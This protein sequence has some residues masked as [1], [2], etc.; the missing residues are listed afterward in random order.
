MRTTIYIYNILVEAEHL[1]MKHIY[2]WKYRIR[3]V[4]W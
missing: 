2:V 3:M 4:L 1:E